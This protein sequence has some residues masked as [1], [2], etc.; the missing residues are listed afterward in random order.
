MKN[1][2]L[3]SVLFALSMFILAGCSK[4][5]LYDSSVVNL[6]KDG[7]KEAQYEGEPNG[8]CE[9][10]VRTYPLIA[11]KHYTAGNVTITNDD[12]NFI[13][14]YVAAGSWKIS[15]IHF[16]IGDSA[17]VP[18]N[19]N[20]TPVPGKFTYKESFNPMVK[21]YKLVIPIA[22]INTDCPLFLAHAVV[23][24]GKKRETAWA[25]GGTNFASYFG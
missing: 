21:N 22:S 25:D 19:G 1:L 16:W 7:M 24:N 17:D 9:V 5:E 6:D 23:A 8:E 18:V 20:N 4:D 13:V 2:K 11:G 10:D 15:E 3:L 14:E 12:E